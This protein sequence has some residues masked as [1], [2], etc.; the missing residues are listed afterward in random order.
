M[1][2]DVPFPQA[3]TMQMLNLVTAASELV[4]NH[5][6]NGGKAITLRVGHYYRPTP[7]DEE[8]FVSGLVSADDEVLLQVFPDQSPAG[9]VPLDQ[10]NLFEPMWPMH[11]PDGQPSL[12]SEILALRMDSI[13]KQLLAG[14]FITMAL[15]G[16]DCYYKVSKIISG[17]YGA[18]LVK[19]GDKP[20]NLIAS[21]MR[22]EPRMEFAVT[23]RK[24]VDVMR[25]VEV[26]HKTVE[27]REVDDV[28]CN[29]ETRRPYFDEVLDANGKPVMEKAID[30]KTG[31]PMIGPNG[32]YILQVAMKKRTVRVRRDFEKV[33]RSIKKVPDTPI[34]ICVS[35]VREIDYN[36]ANCVVDNESHY[37]P[38]WPVAGVLRGEFRSTS[39]FHKMEDVG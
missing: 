11:R 28:V 37:D 29:P 4:A 13:P 7:E 24:G 8:I 19:G 5:F 21:A 39:P 10:V 25:E 1:Q 14:D 2:I 12:V 20:D 36:D 30:A 16:L 31:R 15:S 32:E 9:D 6:A 3:S 33:T 34:F 27:N 18:L 23:L 26:E 35:R 22:G 38:T 17:F